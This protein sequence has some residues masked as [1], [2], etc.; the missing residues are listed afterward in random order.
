MP[1]IHGS[2]REPGRTYPAVAGQ[3][4]PPFPRQNNVSG[5]PGMGYAENLRHL[6][7]SE[8]AEITL[9]LGENAWVPWVRF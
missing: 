5:K 9:A 2:T 4:L 8:A 7:D 3:P 1:A 6:E